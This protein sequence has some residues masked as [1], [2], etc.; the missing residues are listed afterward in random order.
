[1]FKLLV[2]ISEQDDREF[3]QSYGR[4]PAW[5]RRHYKSRSANHVT[6]AP[7]ELARELQ[8]VKAWFDRAKKY[9]K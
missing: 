6:P 9:R 8:F 4:M 7:P 5:F 1:M 2:K 3:Q